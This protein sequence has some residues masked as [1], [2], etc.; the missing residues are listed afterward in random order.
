VVVAVHLRLD[1]EHGAELIDVC[2]AAGGGQDAVVGQRVELGH[3]AGQDLVTGG[4][5]R[6]T[7]DDGEV[8]SGDGQS[9]APVE[10][11][12]GEPPLVRGLCHTV[13]DAVGAGRR[14]HRHAHRMR[15][16]GVDGKTLDAVGNGVRSEKCCHAGLLVAYA[17]G[18]ISRT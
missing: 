8:L 7:G 1:V 6:I 13:V 9:G 17:E 18:Y 15:L 5:A 4:H 11:V 16:A 3:L 2:L 14:V 12:G 10:I